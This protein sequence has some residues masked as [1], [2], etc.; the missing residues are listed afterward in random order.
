MHH[1]YR[2]TFKDNPKPVWI[3]GRDFIT[4]FRN[5]ADTFG[6]CRIFGTRITGT[7]R[8]DPEPMAKNFPRFNKHLLSSVPSESNVS[9]APSQSPALSSPDRQPGN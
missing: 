4:A 9:I 6:D 1:R 3:W 8:D 5:L 7:E 2:F